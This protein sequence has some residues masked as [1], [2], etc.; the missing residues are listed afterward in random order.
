[1]ERFREHLRLGNYRGAF[2]EALRERNPFR[3][4]VMIAEIIARSYR[5]EFVPQLIEALEEIKSPKE[6]AIAE[7]YTARAFYA[8]E[9]ERDGERHFQRAFE[10]LRRMASPMETAEVLGI[11]GKN[12]VLS[13]RYSDGLKAFRKAFD[14]LQSARAVYS[15]VV[16]G[17]VN[18]ARRVEMSAE[19]IPN[20]I[21]L[22]FYE[23]ASDIYESLGFKLQAREI[24]EKMKTAEEV[25]KRGSLAVTELLERGDVDRA[26]QMARFLPPGERAVAML[27]VSYWLFIHDYSDLAREVFNDATEMLLVGKFKAREGEIEAVAYKFLRVGKLNEAMV[28]AGLLRDERRFSELMGEIALTYARRGEVE[29]AKELAMRIGDILIRDKVAKAIREVEET[30]VTPGPRTP[31]EPDLESDDSNRE[32]GEGGSL[33]ADREN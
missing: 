7:S 1:M 17:L 33:D 25:F 26:L 28:L 32:G 21:A 6:L 30:R 23:L 2:A 24:K 8:L 19:E 31:P 15:E 29:Q 12:L 10:E 16:S 4:A 5:E 9:M 22:K 11:I 14:T 3:R 27:N 18:L 20:E 13:G